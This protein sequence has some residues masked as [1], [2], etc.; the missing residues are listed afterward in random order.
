VNGIEGR[1]REAITFVPDFESLHGSC[2][3]VSIVVRWTEI[4]ITNCMQW[5]TALY[6][7]HGNNVNQHLAAVQSLY[8]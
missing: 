2:N 7:Q 5:P 1:G 4:I 6:S 3:Y 8:I